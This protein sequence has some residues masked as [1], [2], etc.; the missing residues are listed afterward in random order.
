MEFA[1]ILTP[2]LSAEV[3][4]TVSEEN[5]AS[6]LGS[7]GLP[8]FASPAMLALMEKAA[9]TS[10]DPLLPPGWSTVGTE[11][12]I[13]HLSATPLGMKVTAR[14]ELLAVDG[15]A[16]S[17][18]VEAFDEAGKIGEG[19]HSRFIIE[20]AKF[21]AKTGGKGK[22]KSSRHYFFT[23]FHKNTSATH[24][25]AVIYGGFMEKKNNRRLLIW[26]PV[27]MGCLVICLIIAGCMSKG[28]GM[29]IAYRPGI[30]EGTGQGYRGPILVWVQVS[31]A[32]IEDIVINSHRENTV[33]GA[34]AMEELLD[35]ILIEGTTD[36]DAISGATV[37]SKGFLE[38]VEDALEK[39]R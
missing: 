26:V 8:V 22:L 34:A 14:A 4:D 12:N 28:L 2:G 29:E 5:T 13:K 25:R 21:M 36:L 6:A 35:T 30:Y 9:H 27:L 38:A 33:P 15:R 7:G 3:E 37:S 1:D 23:F 32:G 11:A 24:P 20:N 10:V 19:S 18:K 31:P 39:A 17:F 16:L